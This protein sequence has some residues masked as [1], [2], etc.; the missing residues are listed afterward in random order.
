MLRSAV[1]SLAACSLFAQAPAPVKKAD[2]PARPW[3]SVTTLSFVGSSGNSEGEAFG[4]THV[5]THRWDDLL[6]TTNLGAARSAST[7][8][9]RRAQSNQLPFVLYNEKDITTV[10]TEQYYGNARL[11]WTFAKDWYWYGSAG[12]ERNRP[13]GLEN[14]NA[15]ATGVGRVWIDTDETRFKTDLGVGRT[16]E[17]MVYEPSDFDKSFTTGVLTAAYRQKIGAHATFSADLAFTSDLSEG[18][19]WYGL[20]RF[21]LTSAMT[22]MLALKLG[23]DVSY[24]NQPAK[25]QVPVFSFVQPVYEVGKVVIDAKKTDVIWTAGLVV[26]F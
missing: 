16:S 18:D 3:T 6:L 2:P 20:G 8:V 24:R 14:R 23:A 15:L 11:D 9:E 25:I 13:A 12:W 7:R 26:T 10:T 21:G 1:T 5:Y 19:N 22:R 17:G 4:L